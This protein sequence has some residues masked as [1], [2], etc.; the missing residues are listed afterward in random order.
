LEFDLEDRRGIFDIVKEEM[1]IGTTNGK[2]E[3]DIREEE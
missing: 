1:N 3:I 2:P